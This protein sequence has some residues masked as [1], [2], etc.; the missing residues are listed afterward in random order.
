[1]EFWKFCEE[2]LKSIDPVYV[3]FAIMFYCIITLVKARI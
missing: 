2:T 1:M 3:C